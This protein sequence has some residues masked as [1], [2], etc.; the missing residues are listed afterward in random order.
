MDDARNKID[1]C[2]PGGAITRREW[3]LS[4]GSAVVL[5]GCSG[6][7][8]E[9]ATQL[10]APGAS[11]LPPGLFLPSLDHLTHALTSDDPFHPIPP[12][13]ETEY[14]RPRSGSFV[15][16]AFA[17]EEFP[18]IR[19]LVEI[20]LG[21]DLK[22]SEETHAPGAPAS[23]CD[24]VA[25]WI[26]L[27]VASAPTVRA[28]ALNLPADQRALAVAYFGTEEPVRELETAEPER[29]CREGLTWLGEE[30]RRRFDEEFSGCRPRRTG[31]A[32]ELG[33]RCGARTRRRR[34]S[35]RASTIC[36]RPNRSA[37]STPRAAA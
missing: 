20:I 4:L 11:A 14:V 3:L 37:G 2:R 30:S 8:G 18:V 15:P 16:Q 28:L 34:T 35:A 5:A 29:V 1:A 22:N 31:R 23:I 12:G 33:E 27:V 7:P 21:E 9:A 24:E 10:A 17:R 36:S 32:R 25:E 26:D 6:A 13:A 19:R